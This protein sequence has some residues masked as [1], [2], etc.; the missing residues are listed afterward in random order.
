VGGSLHG[1]DAIE[2]EVHQNLRSAVAVGRLTSRAP[3]FRIAQP[4]SAWPC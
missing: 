3:G 2:H 4:F 1:F